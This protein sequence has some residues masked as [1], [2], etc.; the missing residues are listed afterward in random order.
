MVYSGFHFP[1]YLCGAFISS[2]S[3]MWY[4]THLMNM[5]TWPLRLMHIFQAATMK[6]AFLFPCDLSCVS[7]H[8]VSCPPF[9][10]RLISESTG[11]MHYR[12]CIRSTC[13][14]K[15]A[16]Q[17]WVSTCSL[18]SY[19]N[20]TRAWCTHNLSRVSCEAVNVMQSKKGSSKIA[21]GPTT[22]YQT[23]LQ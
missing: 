18:C 1:L 7:Y 14:W 11:R 3:V 20:H 2:E 10:S 12:L 16:I 4:F 21:K 6:R 19:W 23:F 22:E 8:H 13:L 9:S 5:L 17:A 15:E